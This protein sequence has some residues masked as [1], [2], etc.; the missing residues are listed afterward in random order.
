MAV[1]LAYRAYAKINLYLDVLNKR[2]D[3]YHDIETI[4]QSVS[5]ADELVFSERQSRLSLAC[6]LPELDSGDENLVMRA[7]KLLR[8]RSGCR[9]GARIRLVK[10]IPIAAGLAGG[11]SDAA[12]ALLALNHLWELGWSRAQLHTLAQE[13]GSD[14]PY[15][16]VGGTVAATRRGDELRSLEPLPTTWF[17]LLHSDVSVSTTRVY[18]SPKLTRRQD[19]PFAG[20]TPT[21]R[22]TLRAL[23]SGHLEQVVFNRMEGPVFANHPHLANVKRRLLDSGCLAAAMSGSGATLFGVCT[24][25]K[26][27]TRI[28]DS[29]TD[30][31]TSVVCSVPT[32]VE[33]IE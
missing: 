22:K 27:A 4:F 8:Q 14:V 18:S 1:T 33:R 12:T 25:R 31:K 28:A 13:L 32:C 21:F 3:G 16:I 17:V 15:C 11:S 20:R 5:L 24:S 29:F 30:Y 6:S 26:H 23:E 2:R 9:L 19:K 10:A 7:A